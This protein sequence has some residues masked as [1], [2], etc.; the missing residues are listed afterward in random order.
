MESETWMLGTG[1]RAA[2]ESVW[3]MWIVWRNGAKECGIGMVWS[4]YDQASEPKDRLPHAVW[5]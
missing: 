5:T 2:K 4:G 3:R 1:K